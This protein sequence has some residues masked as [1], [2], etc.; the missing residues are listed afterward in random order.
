MYS[1]FAQNVNISEYLLKIELVLHS[2]EYQQQYFTLKH[3]LLFVLCIKIFVLHK[4]IFKFKYFFFL[5]D[6]YSKFPPF[7]HIN[8]EYA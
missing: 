8:I 1:Y 4:S 2:N 5:K 7:L 6:R 3:K